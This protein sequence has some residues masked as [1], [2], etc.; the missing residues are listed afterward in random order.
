[1]TQPVDLDQR[2]GSAAVALRRL[3]HPGRDGGVVVRDD[4]ATALRA[5]PAQALIAPRWPPAACGRREPRSTGFL[6]AK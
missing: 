3:A 4:Q 5:E 2:H 1:M 6:R